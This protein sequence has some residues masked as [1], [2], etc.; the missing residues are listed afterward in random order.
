MSI[1]HYQVIPHVSQE[2]TIA[3][4]ASPQFVIQVH[5]GTYSF[6]PVSLKD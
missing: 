6:E 5:E 4:F 1:P 3:Y 2:F